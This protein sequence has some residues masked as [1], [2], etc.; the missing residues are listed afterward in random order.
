M[1]RYLYNQWQVGNFF[2]LAHLHI[3]EKQG[4]AALGVELKKSGFRQKLLW[5]FWLAF[6]FCKNKSK[7]K[8]PTKHTLKLVKFTQT[9]TIS[10]LVQLI[11][12]ETQVFVY[13]TI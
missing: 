10:K 8:S 13:F 9:Y 6:N 11:M 12:Y 2:E 4:G 7:Y 5:A 3:Q 1:N